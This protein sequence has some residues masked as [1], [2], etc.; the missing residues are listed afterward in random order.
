MYKKS[1]KFPNF[2]H[3]QTFS[4]LCAYHF[5]IE[6]L[7]VKKKQPKKLGFPRILAVIYKQCKIIS[8]PSPA[9]ARPGPIEFL[10]SSARPGPIHILKAR[11]RPDVTF[12]GP[13]TALQNSKETQRS[14]R[15]GQVLRIAYTARDSTIICVS[16]YVLPDFVASLGCIE[17]QHIL[18]Y[19]A[20]PL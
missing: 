9:R 2:S 13:I 19:I 11:A 20:K 8:S 6:Q 7:L 3:L 12:L 5:K 18:L 14:F 10:R 17:G 1:S 4:I 16:S 15:P